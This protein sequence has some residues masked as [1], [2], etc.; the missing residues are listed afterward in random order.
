MS[1]ITIYKCRSGS[2]AADNTI[3]WFSLHNFWRQL[4][5]ASLVA[6]TTGYEATIDWS[7]LACE[8][9]SS[10]NEEGWIET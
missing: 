5:A 9:R 10:L 1:I 3:K 6:E 7:K 2:V 4:A 8:I